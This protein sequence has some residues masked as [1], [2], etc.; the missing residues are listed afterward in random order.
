MVALPVRVVGNISSRDG[1]GIIVGRRVVAAG[2][3]IAVVRVQGNTVGAVG[4]DGESFADRFPD[5]C[6]LDG[7]F[8]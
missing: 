7:L 2:R 5:T 6:G 8:L 3:G 1:D 4:V